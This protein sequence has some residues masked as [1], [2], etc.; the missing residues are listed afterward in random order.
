[1]WEKN[2][3]DLP[4]KCPGEGETLGPPAFPLCNSP[5]KPPSTLPQVSLAGTGPPPG[6]HPLAKGCRALGNVLPLSGP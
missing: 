1:M 3:I 4:P 2:S 5:L 6:L